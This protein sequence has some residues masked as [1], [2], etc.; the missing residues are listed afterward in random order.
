M[1]RYRIVVGVL[2]AAFLQGGCRA[3]PAPGQ[4]AAE[5]WPL[6]ALWR[7]MPSNILP[8]CTIPKDGNRLDPAAHPGVVWAMA[9]WLGIS[10]H[11]EYIPEKHL[12]MRQVIPIHSLKIHGRATDIT[13]LPL[14]LP[15]ASAMLSGTG[16]T[17]N[18]DLDGVCT[19][20]A[21][22]YNMTPPASPKDA[23]GIVHDFLERLYL[24]CPSLASLDSRKAGSCFVVRH[25]K[26]TP[27]AARE[28]TLEAF[29]SA[30]YI[31]V[32]LHPFMVAPIP[33]Y[34]RPDDTF[35]TVDRDYLEDVARGYIKP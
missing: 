10:I 12:L 16:G 7:E 11:P 2:L 35:E 13:Y 23:A 15:F 4:P 22:V 26:G 34:I 1:K 14:P 17:S 8:Y 24:R 20:A 25:K 32:Q 31:V 19:V 3:R 27:L 30:H 6:A 21:R 5:T 18:P 33:R 29:V 28:D 9:N